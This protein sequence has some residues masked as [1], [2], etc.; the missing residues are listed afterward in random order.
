MFAVNFVFDCYY[1]VEGIS[2]TQ[3]ADK[4]NIHFKTSI[5]ISVK[6]LQQCCHSYKIKSYVQLKFPQKKKQI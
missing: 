3:R 6:V 4:Q 5:M 1:I 2:H